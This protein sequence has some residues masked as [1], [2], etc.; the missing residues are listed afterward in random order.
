MKNEV[1]VLNVD[2]YGLQESKSKEIEKLYIPMINL[3]SE[4][5]DEFNE[6]VVREVT[7]DLIP[8]AKELRLRIAKIRIQADKSRVEGKAESLRLGK[9]IQG[10]YNTFAYAVESKE[11]KL[12]D[13]EL[14]FEKLETIRIE[15][16]QI[17]R[18][19]KIS[20]YLEPEFID[21][22]LGNMNEIVWDAYF[23]G[24]KLNYDNKVKSEKEAEK[25]RIK[26]EKLD[27]LEQSRKIEIAP[28]A[29]FNN[30][31]EDLRTLPKTKYV[32]LL[33]SL[34]AAKTEHDQ[35]QEKIR[36]E[37]IRLQKEAEE[38]ELL[39]SKRNE[40]LKPYIIF[41]RDYNKMINLD[42]IEYQKELK[43]L[44]IGAKQHYE[45]EA[46]EK[47]RKEKERLAIE[48]EIK[49]KKQKRTSLAIDFLLLNDFKNCPSGM[50][51]KTYNHFIGTLHYS[52]FS[53][54]NELE[55]FKSDVIKTKEAELLKA[56]LKE[57]KEAKEKEQKRLLDIKQNRLKDEKAALLA[58]DKDK[59]LALSNK[60]NNLPFPELNS[61]ESKAILLSVQNLL[62]KTS[63][64]IK[65]KIETI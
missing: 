35:D 8:R 44:K 58:P 54:D 22:D 52:D 38:K 16:L 30:T 32:K 27:K 63:N 14:H 15:N 5:E 51:A 34:I 6:L 4:M 56:E 65:E 46:E 25:L 36:L 9:A 17:E 57:Q 21:N 19:E 64:Y 20:K 42:E 37:N 12:K 50:E 45:L 39:R 62:T 47:E 7:R 26:I 40:E 49:A 53:T 1:V 55:L 29:E 59:L 18:S 31:S 23:S 24:T 2:Q 48:S 43:D 13:I 10:A 3:L 60:I 33:N 61:E 41:I 28:Y 11:Q